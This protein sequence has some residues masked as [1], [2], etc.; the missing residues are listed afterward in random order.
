VTAVVPARNEALNLPHV[1]PPL[2][3]LVD[4]VILVDGHSTDD[5][6]AVARALVPGI[7][8]ILQGGSGKG[9]ALR[10]GFALATGDIIV[11]IDADGSTCPS[12]IPAFIGVLLAG[13]DYAKGTRFAQGAGSAD[14]SLFRR[15]GNRVLVTLARLLHGGRFSD[16]CYGYNAFWT[17]CLEDLRLSGDGFE[18]ETVMNVRALRSGLDV[19]EVPSFERA[20][21][22]GESNLNALFD[23]G[24]VLRA[25]IRELGFKRRHP[26]VRMPWSP[27]RSSRDRDT[28]PPESV[29]LQLEPRGAIGPPLIVEKL[30]DA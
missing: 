10:A 11:T 14:L 6:A 1:L 4:E 9:D 29:R 12:E 7:R 8:V 3:R 15:V 26:R 20:R 24:R 17:R 23:G 19:R 21:R 18:I 13:A 16:L 2:A 25:L 22:Y 28:P 5:T 30:F 27:M